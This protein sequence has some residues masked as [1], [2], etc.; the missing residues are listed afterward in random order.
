MPVVCGHEGLANGTAVVSLRWLRASNF[1]DRW[2]CISRDSQA[3]ANVVSSPVVDYESQAWSQCCRAAAAVGAGELSN[4]PELAA[5]AAAGHGA[6]WPRSIA[7][8]A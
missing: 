5:Q 8:I 3:V 6:T 4:G 7:G 2:D 1:G